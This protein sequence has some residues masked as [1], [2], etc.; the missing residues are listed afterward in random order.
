MP[1]VG[2][3]H[4]SLPFLSP[5]PGQAAR[6][7]PERRDMRG[8]GP[9]SH[10]LQFQT[11]LFAL[12]S[13]LVKNFGDPIDPEWI[14]GSFDHPWNLLQIVRGQK[15]LLAISP[16]LPA[17]LKSGHLPTAQSPPPCSSGCRGLSSPY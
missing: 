12:A 2:H 1:S 6:E 10:K 8:T 13:S 17:P 16:H 15:S 5:G 3:S 7:K 11:L 4:V 9:D 14:Y